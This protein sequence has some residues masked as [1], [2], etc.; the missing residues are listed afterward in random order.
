MT[1]YKQVALIGSFF[2]FLAIVGLTYVVW[3]WNMETTNDAQIDGLIYSVSPRIN[4]FVSNVLIEDNQYIKAGTPLI[5]LDPAPYEAALAKAKA[6]EIALLQTAPLT[7]TEAIYRIQ[8]AKAQIS[9]AVERIAQARQQVA[10]AKYNLVQAQAE[11]RYNELTYER[12]KRLVKQAVISEQDF[13][14]A[15]ENKDTS[16]A[17]VEA[18]QYSL[19]EAKKALQVAIEEEPESEAQLGIAETGELEA[20]IN[21]I[22]A[23]AQAAIVRLARLELSWTTIRAPIDGYVANKNV[24]H[25][26]TVSRGQ[27][28]LDLVPRSSRAKWVTANF[29]ETQVT[30]MVPGNYCTIDVDTYP[31]MKL[32]GYIESITAGTG[33][34]FSLFPPENATGNYVK[35]VQRIP[36]RIRLTNYDPDTMPLLRNGMSVEP[37]VYTNKIAEAAPEYMKINAGTFSPLLLPY[38]TPLDQPEKRYPVTVPSTQPE[39]G[40]ELDSPVPDVKLPPLPEAPP[41]PAKPK[42]FSKIWPYPTPEA[43]RESDDETRLVSRL[44]NRYLHH[45]ARK[46]AK[47]KRSST[48]QEQ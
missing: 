41:L 26:A 1:F 37:T 45:I 5:Q 17:V 4:G 33:S 2:T 47:T 44:L 32:E 11:S 19:E 46:P 14:Q 35:V 25:G 36:V 3:T 43:L 22:Q 39:A 16:Y 38:D 29:K 24:E 7:E 15:R 18:A 31:D 27:T 8:S 21:L 40:P 6:Q 12:M 34:I 42:P 30:Y 48:V 23:Q 9:T 28:L 20:S 10:V 13:D